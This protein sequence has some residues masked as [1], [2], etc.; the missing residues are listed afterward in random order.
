LEVELIVPIGVKV[1]RHWLGEFGKIEK[2]IGRIERVDGSERGRDEY[3]KSSGMEGEVPEVS[4]GS[5][6]Q[7]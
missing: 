2:E 4:M 7:S 6:K 1:K 3:K 5:A